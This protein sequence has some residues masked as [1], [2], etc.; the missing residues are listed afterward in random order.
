MQK[1]F[2]GGQIAFVLHI[3]SCRYHFSVILVMMVFFIIDKTISFLC[4]PSNCMWQPC[5]GY[6]YLS[7][8]ESSRICKRRNI[9][10]TSTCWQHSTLPWVCATCLKTEET[11]LMITLIR[12][13]V[14]KYVLSKLWSTSVKTEWKGKVKLSG[15]NVLID[16]LYSLNL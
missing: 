6:S 16:N 15:E 13:P 9:Q 5:F 10:V 8:V 4:V 12:I 2:K 7:R 14:K 1:L 11:M 3:I